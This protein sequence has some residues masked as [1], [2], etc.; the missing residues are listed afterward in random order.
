[1]SAAPA[2][3]FDLDGTLV[4]TAPDLHDTLNAVLGRHGRP[5]VG[6]DSVRAMVGDGARALLERGFA[7]TGAP[8]APAQVDAAFADFLSHYETYV[9]LHSRPF[10]GV[11]AALD[12]LKAAGWRLGVCTN[13]PHRLARK[14]LDALGLLDRFGAV[15]GGD[16]L[17]V[18]K[19]AAGHLLGTLDALGA[20][21]DRSIMVGD[22]RN[23]VA[24]ARAAGLPVILVSFGYTAVPPAALG[25]DRVIDHFAELQSA[26]DRLLPAGAA[27]SAGNS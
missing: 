15:V 6:L 21:A 9:A 22:S 25:A 8:A 13:K 5:G 19:P 26:I 11:P 2:V 12:A 27:Q 17:A 24:V 1:M 20:A 10:P 4:D 7:A 18:R 14:L 16:S 3:V 23:D